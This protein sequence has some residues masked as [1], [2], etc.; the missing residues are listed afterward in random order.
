MIFSSIEFLLYFL[1]VFFILYGVTPS[2]Y[3]N[4]VL[5]AGSLIFYAFG[6]PDYLLLLVVSV[7][8]NYF[9]GLHLGVG[10]R[11][12]RKNKRSKIYKRKKVLLTAAVIGNISVLV[13]FKGSVY[14]G[15]GLNDMGLPLGISFYT[16]QILSYLIDVYRGEIV[17]EDSLVKLAT[18]V[19]MFPQLI[20]G[21]IVNYDE[22]QSA[23]SKRQCTAFGIQ[24]GLKVFTMGLAS[25][26]LLADRVGLLWREAQTTGF[27]SISTG[28]AWLAAVAYSMKIYFDFYGYSLMAIGL[29]RML[30]FELPENFNMPYMARS[31]REFYRRWH[32]TLGRWFCRYVY[33]PMGGSRKGELRTI[34]NL[35]LVW[36]LTSI[37][38]GATPNFFIWGGLLW[39]CIVLERQWE[40]T[41]IGKHL[42]VL[43][44]VYLWFVIPITWVCFAVPQL[45]E[46]RVYLG[47]MFGLV[48]GINV[49]SNDWL[50]SLERYWFLLGV[51]FLACTPLVQK[52]Y[53]KI[54][55]TLPG[56]IILAILFWIC[57][58]RITIEGNNPFMYFRF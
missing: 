21:P 22:V 27:E 6:E 2:K 57:I 1:P 36:L 37:W 50:S 55:D 38:H 20:A 47:R 26:V 8:V 14:G 5:L 49:S 42:K 15:A 51:S 16:F 9:I 31:V 54:K 17:R 7:L 41:G 29:G 30:G 46:L 43:P 45:G 12:N 34:G 18:Y 35:L 44:H 23:L 10:G 32:I 52:L 28:M 24:D 53:R 40:R 33:I 3:K 39:F 58:W 4:S 25:K 48:Q 11:K 56:E 13:L 19:T